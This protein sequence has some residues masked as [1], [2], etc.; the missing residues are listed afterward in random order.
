MLQWRGL[1]RPAT[2]FGLLYLHVALHSTLATT[3]S[4]GDEGYRIAIIGGGIGGTFAAKYLAEY[5]VHHRGENQR[6]ECLLREIVVF[7]VS[8]PPG[9]TT[10]SS[11]KTRSSADPRPR[12]WQG[13][14]VSSL[15]LRDGTVIELGASIIYSRNQLVVEMMKGDAEYLVRGKPMGLGNKKVEEKAHDGTTKEENTDIKQEPSGFGIYHGDQQWLLNP[16]IFSSF[17]SML[18]SIL[19]PVYFMWRYNF[20]YFR[21]QRAVKQAVR[22]FDIVYALLHDTE[23]DVTYFENPMDMWSAIGLKSLAGRI[24]SCLRACRCLCL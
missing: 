20:D 5:D 7:D 8:P 22:A 2:L 19:K 10:T 17:P 16:S 9:E 3:P 13:S 21:L 14:R 15:T 4:A 12:H 6:S 24:D 23:K 1:R 11:T 18:R